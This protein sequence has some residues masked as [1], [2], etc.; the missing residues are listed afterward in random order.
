MDEIGSTFLTPAVP[1]S[2][3]ILMSASEDSDKNF[4][5]NNS[6]PLLWK[7][8][9][10]ME[11]PPPDGHLAHSLLVEVLYSALGLYHLQVYQE[12]QQLH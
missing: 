7:T 5:F 11:S 3:I 12:G 8:I 9:L 6:N 10:S 2:P 4:N 1:Q